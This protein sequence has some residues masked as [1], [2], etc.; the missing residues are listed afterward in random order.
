MLTRLS[1]LNRCSSR[2]PTVCTKTHFG[3][4]VGEHPHMFARVTP[5]DR[6]QLRG[7]GVPDTGTQPAAGVVAVH[8]RMPQQ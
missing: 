1:T 8:A 7:A 2:T 3:Y 6:P 5:Q 4:Q